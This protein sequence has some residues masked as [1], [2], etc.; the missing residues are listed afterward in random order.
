VSSLGLEPGTRYSFQNRYVVGP[1][2]TF[3]LDGSR[4]STVFG[5]VLCRDCHLRCVF[6]TAKVD[7]TPHMLRHTFV[8][9]L[10]N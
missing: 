1:S 2:A 4:Y 8:H 10:L 3:L 9:S 6:E 5:R 7:G